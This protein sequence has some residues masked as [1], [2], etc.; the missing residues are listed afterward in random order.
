MPIL[1]QLANIFTSYGLA[2]TDSEAVES[3]VLAT[4]ALE[5]A[6]VLGLLAP[7][8]DA[9]RTKEPG[10]DAQAKLGDKLVLETFTDPLF[11]GTPSEYEPVQGFLDNCPLVAVLT[12]M[13][14]VPDFRALLTAEA[15]VRQRQ[16]PLF[17]LPAAPGLRVPAELEADGSSSAA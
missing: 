9:F 15:V 1:D 10:P 5:S 17:V 2:A 3:E 8:P 13:A 4:S 12:A 7:A 16:R 6:P 14:H 11:A